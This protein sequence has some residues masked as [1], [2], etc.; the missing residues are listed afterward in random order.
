MSHFANQPGAV[1]ELSL[2]KML[3][4]W[5]VPSPGRRISSTGPANWVGTNLNEAAAGAG[6][7]VCTV[8]FNTLALLALASS[9]AHESVISGN[10]M[11]VGVVVGVFVLVAV[12]VGVGV[13]V[14]VMVAVPVGVGVGVLVAGLVAVS[15]GAGV[16]VAGTVAASTVGVA[17]GVGVLV[18][19]GVVAGSTLLLTSGRKMANNAAP[20]APSN[21]RLITC[22]CATDVNDNTNTETILTRANMESRFIHSPIHTFFRYKNSS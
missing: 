1:A 16:R 8:I 20:F 5:K 13:L 15:V 2:L 21:R 17:L 14:A 10:G 19:S 9:A 4:N 11:E 22:D 7:E 12:A 3:T 6:A 18:A